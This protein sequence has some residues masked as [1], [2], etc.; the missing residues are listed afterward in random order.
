MALL[1]IV[2]CP[3]SIVHRQA[4]QQRTFARLYQDFRQRSEVLRIS[5]N[6]YIG[7]YRLDNRANGLYD[8]VILAKLAITRC[9]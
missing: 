5:L 7:L 1:S 8:L 6:T 4:N 3:S 2:Y 9:L